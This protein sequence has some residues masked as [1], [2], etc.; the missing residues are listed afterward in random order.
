MEAIREI[1]K[2][3]DREII[4][5]TGKIAKQANTVI[6]TLGETAVLVAVTLSREPK[7]LPFL[8]LTVEYRDANAAAGKIPGGYFKREGRPT[9]QEIL[10]C[11][12]TDRPIRPLFPKTY[13]YDTQVIGHVL[14]NDLQNEPDV[15]AMTG[16]SAALMISPAPWSGPIAGIR[17][18]RIDGKLIAYPTFSEM[19]ESDLNLVVACS[20]DAI[21]MV[22]AGANQMS[23]ADMI[24]ALM[25]AK[26][27]SLPLIEAQ[28]RLQARAGKTKIPWKD[29]AVDEAFRTLIMDKARPEMVKALQ[30]LGKHERH[31]AVDAIKVKVI[32]ELGEAVIGRAAEIE[33][34]FNKL[35]KQIVRKATIA[36]R[37]IDGRT[38]TDIRPIYIEAHPYERPHGSALFQRGETQAI[39]TTTLGTERDAQ[40][41]DTIRGDVNNTFLL[42]YNFPPYCVG[43]ARPMRGTSRREIGH[44]ALAHRAL[45]AVLPDSE[46]FPYTIRIVSDTTES[47]GS[48]SMAAVCG[49]CLS[50]MDAGVPIKAP[51]AGIAMGLIQEGNDIAVLSDILGDEDHLG[52]MDFK[53]CGTKDGI[54][55]L[56]MD[57][58]IHG[59]TRAILET[60]LEQA[61]AGRLHILGK[62]LETL[63]EPRPQIS[64][65]APRVETVW[66][67][68]DK[69]RSI[70]GPGG[71]IIRGI[72]EQ[73]GVVININDD[74]RVTLASPNIDA[75][76]KAKA[77]IEGL[78]FEAEPGQF[79]NGVVKRIVDFGAFVEIMPG[80]DG[81]VHIS[82]LENRRIERVTDVVSE[83]DDVVVKVINIDDQGRIRLSRK[84]AFG[85][86]PD[87]VL[88]LRG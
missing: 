82:E 37:R 6:M 42:H 54:T 22:E 71:K 50:M 4:L 28:E 25:F 10:T 39:T 8:P 65:Y 64:R 74:G 38:T 58:K 27:Q 79:Y 3:G 46:T 7:D 53:C 61:R 35:E 36:G 29:P 20:R 81:L 72:T 69:I 88:N 40:R 31:A 47:N 19:Q 21:V 12:L 63:P 15:L 76:M 56:Q 73:T 16:A 18:G 70:I 84:Q 77:I 41:L 45:L 75:I 80:T 43:E 24:D 55:A 9:E 2:I 57:I 1:A 62:M 51:V 83:G 48:S 78:T 34:A 85:V 60:A 86:D 67:K 87:E 66:V 14:S 5:E 44:G 17:V 49:G 30:I 32:T 59:L 11:R 33:S 23:E 52:D 13:R 26:E 68:I